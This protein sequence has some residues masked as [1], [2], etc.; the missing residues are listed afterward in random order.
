VIDFQF[1]ASDTALIC[2]PLERAGFEMIEIGH[3]IRIGSSRAGKGQA[4]ETDEAYLRAAAET[5]KTARWG[6]FC[7][8]G[9]AQLE[10]I[11]MAAEYGMSFI[12]IGTNAT[13]VEEFDFLVSWNVI[14]YEDNEEAINEAIAKYH[15]VLKPGGRF[16]V[17]TAG[18]EDSILDNGITLGKHR[19]QIGYP[20]DFRQGQVFFTSTRQIMFNTI[21]QNVFQNYWLAEQTIFFLLKQQ[22]VL[23]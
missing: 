5:L 10:D 11:D 9:I 6:M 8:P 12:R 22:I 23:L 20:D 17:S 1:T 15:R 14:Y 18:P 4:A 21:L 16:F 13:E 3:G 19:Y 7:I 2:G